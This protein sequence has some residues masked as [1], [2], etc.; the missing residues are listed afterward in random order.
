MVDSEDPFIGREP[1][2]KAL[3]RL[4]Q[5]HQSQ[6]LSE[7]S[8]PNL[9]SVLP[10]DFRVPSFVPKAYVGCITPWFNCKLLEY[11][12]AYHISLINTINCL[13]GC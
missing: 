8:V 3:P 6:S 2:G 10:L 12:T 9:N 11:R 4:S 5:G 13:S 7:L 1:G